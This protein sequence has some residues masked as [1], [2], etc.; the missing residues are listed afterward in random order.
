MAFVVPRSH[1]YLDKL[2]LCDYYYYFEVYLRLFEQTLL[3]RQFEAP[4]ADARDSGESGS[5]GTTLTGRGIRLQKRRLSTWSLEEVTGRTGRTG[6]AEEG[7]LEGP[8]EG[9]LTGARPLRRTCL[10]PVRKRPAERASLQFL[11]SLHL[12]KFIEP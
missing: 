9:Y 1:I 11:F 7:H 12:N 2:R 5:A 6:S 8:R 3:A 10:S 4:R